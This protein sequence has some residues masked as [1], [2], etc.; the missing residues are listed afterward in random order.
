MLIYEHRHSRIKHHIYIF[1][2][3]MGTKENTQLLVEV[4]VRSRLLVAPCRVMA[5]SKRTDLWQ[6]PGCQSQCVEQR[7]CATVKDT[8]Q[9]NTQACTYYHFLL[10]VFPV[11]FADRQHKC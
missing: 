1:A 11:N 8:V 2:E 9:I 7:H 4:S 6:R 5:F 10:N 3:K